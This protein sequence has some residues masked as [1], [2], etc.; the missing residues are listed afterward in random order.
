MKKLVKLTVILMFG[1]FATTAWSSNIQI[2]ESPTIE[3]SGNNV[4]VKFGLSWDYSWR[5]VDPN[6]WD[7]AWVF[8]KFRVGSGPWEHMYLDHN[9]VPVAG[10]DNGVAMTHEYG[11]S[12]VPDVNGNRNRAVGVF[13]YRRNNG[14]GNIRWEDVTL[15]WNRAEAGI[16]HGSNVLAT[17]EITVRVFAIE[18]VYV[19][20][21]NFFVGSGNNTAAVGEFARADRHSSVA[22]PFLITSEAAIPIRARPGVG[23][24]V[25]ADGVANNHAGPVRPGGLTTTSNVFTG[26]PSTAAPVANSIGL[27][28]EGEEGIPAAFPKGHRA[29]YMMK[30]E[31]TQGAYVDFLNTLT[32]PQQIMRTRSTSETSAATHRA[33]LQSNASDRNYIKVV[34]QG[35]IEFGVDMNNNNIMN[36]EADGHGVA[37]AMNILDLM[38]YLDFA[39]LRPM[40]ELEFEKAAR[41]PREAI[42]NEFAWGS[43]FWSTQAAQTGPALAAPAQHNAWFLDGGLPTERPFMANVNHMA[44]SQWAVGRNG[45]FA[46]DSSGRV[47]SGASYWGIMELSGN[48]WELAI[49]VINADGRAYTGQHGDGRLTPGGSQDVIGWPVN[50][51]AFGIRGGSAGEAIGVAS[52]HTISGRTG[53][54]WN[55]GMPTTTMGGAGNSWNVGG[56]GVRTAHTQSQ[57][58]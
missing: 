24:F 13:L 48:L 30:Y 56:R 52:S 27:I 54:F 22:E 19:P 26:N 42:P 45:M 9:F 7:A 1:F 20:E 10:N 33:M 49:N 12:F 41:G 18:M 43:T 57:L 32:V 34:R 37:C 58:P 36:E 38:A 16:Y 31:I 28:G 51:F 4:L 15:R 29:F 14:R 23:G 44:A 40:T 8:V 6:N 53:A 47:I 35:V 2:F 55:T 25:D 5:T 46:T 50:H 17:D 39:G 21:G 3:H 11:S